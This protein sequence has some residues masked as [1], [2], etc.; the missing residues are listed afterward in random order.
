MDSEEG[1]VT[2]VRPGLVPMRVL[3]KLAAAEC[4]NTACVHAHIRAGTLRTLPGIDA[5]WERQIFQLLHRAGCAMT[6]E[7]KQ[8]VRQALRRGNPSHGP[9]GWWRCSPPA[10]SA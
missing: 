6:D 1:G 10:G 3:R 4:E 5:Y 7:E 8:E 9:P 2:L